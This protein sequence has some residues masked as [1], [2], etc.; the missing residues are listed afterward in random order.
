[1]GYSAIGSFAG[2]CAYLHKSNSVWFYC[3][4]RFPIERL[5][6]LYASQWVWDVKNKSSYSLD[7]FLLRGDSW[8]YIGANCTKIHWKSKKQIR[9]VWE[10]FHP[11]P[12]GKGF[13]AVFVVNRLYSINI[14]TILYFRFSSVW[15]NQLKNKPFAEFLNFRSNDLVT[16]RISAFWGA[17]LSNN[18]FVKIS[19]F[20]GISI[21]YFSFLSGK[22]SSYGKSE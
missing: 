2:L 20:F 8:T 18:S 16:V 4:Y 1:M 9:H 19:N 17:I 5:Y 22:H 11:I 14:I 15:L 10:S 13:P 6:S 3:T 12:K 21:I 7:T